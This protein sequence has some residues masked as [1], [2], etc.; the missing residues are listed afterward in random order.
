MMTLFIKEYPKTIAMGMSDSTVNN[1]IVGDK[2]AKGTSFF[3]TL[4]IVRFFESCHDPI[5]RRQ[6]GS[7]LF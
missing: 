5:I 4:C 2:Y 6:R 1:N 3:V 7:I